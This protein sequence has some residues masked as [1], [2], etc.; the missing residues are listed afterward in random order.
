M[1]NRDLAEAYQAGMRHAQD[2]PGC[3]VCT[4]VDPPLPPALSEDERTLKDLV[5]KG[6]D[7]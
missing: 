7:A 2:C 1:S 4:R 3:E 6:G 5:S